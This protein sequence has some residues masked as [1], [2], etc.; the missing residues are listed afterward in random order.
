[1]K[2]VDYSD[3]VSNWGAF[4]DALKAKGYDVIYRYLSSY[5]KGATI[6]ELETAYSR[7]FKVG[8]YYETSETAALGGFD[9]GAAHAKS[10]LAFLE[11]L[12]VPQTMPV[13]YTVDFDAT[14]QQLSGPVREYFVGVRS[15][16]AQ[17]QIGVYGGYRS[18][19]YIMDQG[20]AA[21]AVQTEA[22]SYLNGT[23]KPVVWHP[24]ATARQWTVHGPGNIGGIVCDGL[25]IVGDLP[26]YDP[27]GGDEMTQE[28]YK[29]LVLSMFARQ[30]EN[31][32]IAMATIRLDPRQ[33]QRLWD[34]KDAK[35]AARRKELGLE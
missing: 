8:F 11:K 35:V 20:L 30:L 33:A 28:E 29:R 4:F 15:V 12:H 25:D 7:G 17:R 22:W 24:K 10:A 13:C 14:A 19:A 18:V 32:A 6:A 21:F 26:V 31:E 3:R 5:T 16:V 9:R 1:M 2:G 34:E 23:S 27:N